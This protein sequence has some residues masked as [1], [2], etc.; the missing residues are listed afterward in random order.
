MSKLRK[1]QRV[2]WSVEPDRAWYVVDAERPSG[3]ILL[4]SESEKLELA[5]PDDVTPYVVEP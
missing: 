1:N 4:E 2:V 3:H 5:H